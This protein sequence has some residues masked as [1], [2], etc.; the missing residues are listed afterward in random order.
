MIV[1]ISGTETIEPENLEPKSIKRNGWAFSNRQNF[2]VHLQ[3]DVRLDTY[4]LHVMPGFSRCQVQLFRTD[5]DACIV[6]QAPDQPSLDVCA[7][8][9][10]HR[11]EFKSEL[12]VAARH[13]STCILYLE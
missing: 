13:E 5:S 10:K 3:I 8:S 11:Y 6:T 2:P 7:E 9:W 4:P 1:A 12:V